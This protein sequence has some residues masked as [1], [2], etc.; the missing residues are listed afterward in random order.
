MVQRLVVVL[1][2]LM[3]V[4]VGCGEDEPE[5]SSVEDL[6]N[7]IVWKKDSAKMVLIPAGSFEM[8]DSKNEPEDWMKPARPV[9]RVELD[10]FYMDAYE[11]T[12]GQFKQFVEDS[13]LKGGMK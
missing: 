8:G 2:V 1:L 6:K 5:I 13:S 3:V 11:V 4:F 10:A 12:V 9:H 7:N